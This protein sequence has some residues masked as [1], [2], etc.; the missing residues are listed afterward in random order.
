MRSALRVFAVVVA[1]VALTGF[2]IPRQR[3]EYTLTPLLD[4]GTLKAVQ[5]DVIFRGEASGRTILNLPNEWGG[6]TELYHAI[7]DLKPISNAAIA[8]GEDA[9]Q[10]VL[11]YRPRALVHFQYVVFQDWVGEPRAENGNPYRPIVQPGYFHFIG[12]TFLVT[13]QLDDTT[14]TSVQI[15]DLPHG[16]RFASDLEHHG[17][18][19]GRVAPSVAVAGD[20]RVMHARD[21]NIRVAM[22][23]QWSFTDAEFA[24]GVTDIMSAERAFWGDPSTPYLVTVMQL[25]SPNNNWL[26]IGGTGLGDAFAF[27][28][29]PN[30][31]YQQIARTLAHEAIHTWIPAEVGGMPDGA[32]EIPDYWF[33]EG[34]TDFYTGRLMVRGHLWTPAA[35]AADLNQMLSEYASSPVRTE[36]NSRVVADF[37][38]DEEVSKLPYQRGRLL[39]TIWDARL[40]AM[41]AHR[42]MNW[43]VQEMRS[44]ARIGPALHAA[45]LFEAVM[46][47]QGVDVSADVEQFVDHGAPILLDENIFAPCGRVTTRDVPSFSRGFDINATTAN[48]NVISDVDPTLP[49][50]AAGLRDGM[51]LVRRDAGTI[52]DSMHELAYVVRDGE[53]ERTIRYM[54]HGH[55]QITL[56]QLVLDDD[57]SGDKL[58]QCERVISGG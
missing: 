15:R 47:E 51:V 19:L 17:L 30:A 57:L 7:H 56:Q 37:W 40:R 16:W 35:F 46:F 44:R 18:V 52:G 58:V 53:T 10:R 26:S 34:F 4:H 41:P 12:S 22:R 24:N 11:T 2:G 45:P 9:A 55:G 14:P 27:F 29:S 8:D 38:N 1:L 32:A 3:V 39:A 23:G 42:D 25:T 13:P 50:Y 49:A 31:G 28:A 6:Q 21:H 20:F 48:N 43:I 33:S 5:V 36:P 54:P